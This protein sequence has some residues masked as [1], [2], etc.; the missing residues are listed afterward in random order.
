M[1]ESAI[2]A[3]CPAGCYYAAIDP[4]AVFV[5]GFWLI[6]ICMVAFGFYYAGEN[7]LARRL[8]K[9]RPEKAWDVCWEWER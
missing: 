9:M 8:K 6:T 7:A 1:N 4:S 3:S 5:A 2:P